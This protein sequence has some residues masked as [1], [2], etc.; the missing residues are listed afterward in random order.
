MGLMA[1]DTSVLLWN[2]TPQVCTNGL[3][4]T[5]CGWGALDH[6]TENRYTEAAWPHSR[7]AEWLGAGQ[8]PLLHHRVSQVARPEL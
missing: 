4:R 5:P 8:A 7:P 1:P 6:K 2:P 3:A